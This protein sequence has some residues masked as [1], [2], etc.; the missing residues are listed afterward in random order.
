MEAALADMESLEPEEKLNYTKIAEKHG[1]NRVT[2]SR[3]HQG[4][5]ASRN[6]KADNQL[7]LHPL[8]EQELL[9]YIL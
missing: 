2:L 1:V 4:V 5:S 8:Q 9:Q 7:D 6:T 3:R